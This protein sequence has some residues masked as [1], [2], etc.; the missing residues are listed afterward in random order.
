MILINITPT[1]YTMK[2]LSFA[3]HNKYKNKI[4]MKLQI[5]SVLKERFI[6]IDKQNSP[7]NFAQNVDVL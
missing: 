1:I 7:W 3:I 5:L 2:N 4:L 6:S